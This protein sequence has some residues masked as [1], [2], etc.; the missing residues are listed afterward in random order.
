MQGSVLFF[1]RETRVGVVRG[2]DGR[3]YKFEPGD[4]VGGVAASAGDKIDFEPVEGR[5][6]EI[7][8]LRS[9]ASGAAAE[10]ARNAVS[11][12]FKGIRKTTQSVA[13]H[14]ETKRAASST[15]GAQSLLNLAFDDPRDWRPVLAVFSILACLLPLVSFSGASTSLMG[16]GGLIGDLG[17]LAEQLQL[18]AGILG[19]AGSGW[20]AGANPWGGGG[21]TWGGARPVANPLAEASSLLGWAKVGYLLY[22]VPVLAAV[23]CFKGG[24]D[25]SSSSMSL[26]HG[27]ACLMPIV[28]LTVAHVAYP[29]IDPVAA[30]NAAALGISPLGVA[31][32]GAWLLVAIGAAQIMSGL[33]VISRSPASVMPRRA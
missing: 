13:S 14:I 32:F 31:G 11:E 33:G 1:D 25:A 22:L 21:N 10:T 7:C 5:A 18:T 28:L 8:V 29:I 3:R 9:G 27:V 24:R 23:V 26:A 4:Y 30:R 19:G 16:I 12:V 17:I 6:T 15:D 2:D 20:G